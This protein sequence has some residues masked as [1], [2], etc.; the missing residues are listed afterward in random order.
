MEARTLFEG[1]ATV[2]VDG[3]AHDTY[4]TAQVEVLDDVMVRWFGTLGWMGEAPKD[5]FHGEILDMSFSDGREG[6]IQI[7]HPPAKGEDKLEFIG[8]DLPPGFMPLYQRALL[9][10]VGEMITAE[11]VQGTSFRTW[12]AR[13]AGVLSVVSMF[14]AIWLSEYQDKLIWSGFLL[15][16]LAIGL[17]PPRPKPL[18]EVPSDCPHQ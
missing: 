15:M 6:K 5:L 10:D 11:L 17:I 8:Q 9:P 13:I 18:P 14:T 3:V 16:V 7:P 2:D 1:I 4:M 12:T